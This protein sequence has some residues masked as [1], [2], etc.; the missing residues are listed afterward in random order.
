LI[1]HLPLGR[2]TTYGRCGMTRYLKWIEQQAN[3]EGL[4]GM[5]TDPAIEFAPASSERWPDIEAVIGA[6][7]D[8]RHCWCAY[9]YRGNADYRAGRKDGSNRTWLESEIAGGAAP[10][11]VAYRE[12]RPVGWCGVGPR[13]AMGRLARSRNLAAVDGRPVWSITCFVV[14]KEARR[15]GLTR[16]LIAA[17]VAHAA[18]QGAR[19]VEAYPLDLDR[20]AYPGELFVGTLR[21]FLAEGFV[22]V[23]RRAPTRPIVRLELGAA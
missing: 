2:Q 21:A 10:G 6:C 3:R 17:A 12:G 4:P 7:G 18:A 16:R 23:A 13:A 22:E 5:S 11:V 19:V 9:W 1:F 15:Q 14:V 8:A 20:K